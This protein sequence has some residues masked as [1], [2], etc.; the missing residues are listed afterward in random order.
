[1]VLVS[2]PIIGCNVAKGQKLHPE[3]FD[4]ISILAVLIT[5][6]ESFAET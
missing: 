2:V 4:L 6:P 5:I 1:M 3:T